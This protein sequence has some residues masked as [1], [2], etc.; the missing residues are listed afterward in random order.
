MFDARQ[1]LNQTVSTSMATSVKP[2]PEGEWK[3]MVSTQIPIEEWFG[4]AT[5]KDKS[6][7][8]DKTTP[9]VKI[10][11]EIVDDTARALAQREKI[12]VYYDCFLDLNP[13][14]TLATGDDKNVRIGALRE[15]LG[16]N[17]ESDW[18]FQR[19]FGAGPFMAKINHQTNKNNPDEKFGRVGRVSRIR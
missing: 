3:A 19:F 17:Q 15:A 14:G 1:F 7:G 11:F 4:E 9:T 6:T 12:I 13:D 10:P 8:Q 2:P 16:Q 18:T 5:W